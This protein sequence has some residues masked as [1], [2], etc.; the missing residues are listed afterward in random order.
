MV[1]WVTAEGLGLKAI[2]KDAFKME[3]IMLSSQKESL[4][5]LLLHLTFD[6]I[7]TRKRTQLFN[8]DNVVHTTAP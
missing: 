4:G 5:Q 1:T 3:L 7:D 2:K 6:W 8:K